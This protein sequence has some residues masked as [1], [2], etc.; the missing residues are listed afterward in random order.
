MKQGHN[1]LIRRTKAIRGLLKSI[2]INAVFLTLIIL[3]FI[4]EGLT[5]SISIIG[6]ILMASLFLGN[7]K[8]LKATWNSGIHIIR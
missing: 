7:F 6:L 3:S 2:T 1:L 8:E 5:Q 4:S